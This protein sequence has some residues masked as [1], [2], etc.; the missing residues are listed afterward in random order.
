MDTKG[1]AL[2]RLSQGAI[3]KENS[4]LLGSLPTA[5]VSRG[6]LR[7]LYSGEWI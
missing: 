4:Y 5:F 6:K 3:G 1:I 2:A 7:S